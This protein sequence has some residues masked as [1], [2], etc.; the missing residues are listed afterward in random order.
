MRLQNPARDYAILIGGIEDPLR[1]K[2]SQR[3]II[4]VLQ[5]ASATTGEMAAGW[6]VIMG[7]PF[8]CPVLVD[9]I[10]GC[11]HRHMLAAFCQSVP[12]GRDTDDAVCAHRTHSLNA[13]LTVI[14][15]VGS[16]RLLIGVVIPKRLTDRQGYDRKLRQRDPYFHQG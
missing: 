16:P 12:L 10:A 8:D 3:D 15:F 14:V 1:D 5:L 4:A 9:Y 7:A 11:R 13:L 2:L 6:F